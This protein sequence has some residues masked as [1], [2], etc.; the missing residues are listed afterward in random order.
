MR[1]VFL[2]QEEENERRKQLL[3]KTIASID[4]QQHNQ[5][6]NSDEARLIDKKSREQQRVEHFRELTDLTSVKS[7]NEQIRSLL[8]TGDYKAIEVYTRVTYE[9]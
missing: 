3:Q 9:L 4:K 6:I 5:L 1:E 8:L 7:T 2:Q